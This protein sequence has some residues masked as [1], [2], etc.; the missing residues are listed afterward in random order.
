[1]FEIQLDF[2]PLVNKRPDQLISK[3]APGI[4]YVSTFFVKKKK[5]VLR[6]IKTFLKQSLCLLMSLPLNKEKLRRINLKNPIFLIFRS[7]DYTKTFFA[8]HGNQRLGLREF[9][10]LGHTAV[11]WVESW[12]HKNNRPQHL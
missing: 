4:H 2:G 11:S 12:L 7:S 8:I 1:M 10:Q 6:K 3:S 9:M 5:N